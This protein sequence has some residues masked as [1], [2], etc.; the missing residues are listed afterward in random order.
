MEKIGRVTHYFA[1][2]SVAVIELDR[3]LET[4]DT[5]R[6]KGHTTDFEMPVASMQIDHDNVDVAEA[7]QSIGLKVKNRVRANDVVYK[8]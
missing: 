2:I 4:G 7:G 5:I 1:N 3:T 6:I 8:V